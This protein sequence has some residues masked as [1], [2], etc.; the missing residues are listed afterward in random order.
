MIF[1][2]NIIMQ[3][4]IRENS[5]MQNH[6]CIKCHSQGDKII[7][8]KPLAVSQD[9]VTVKRVGTCPATHQREITALTLYFCHLVVN[10]LVRITLEG[11]PR[12]VTWSGN[13]VQLAWMLVDSATCSLINVQ[14]QEF[15]MFSLVFLPSHRV[16]PSPEIANRKG[17]LS[18]VM[19]YRFRSVWQC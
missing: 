2:I 9:F 8:G 15:S 13:A 12:I 5:L 11:C 7:F 16:I 10:F 14:A 17:T 19:Q 4:S 3:F 6:L 1:K 18:L